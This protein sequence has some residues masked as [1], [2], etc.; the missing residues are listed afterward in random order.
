MYS[1]LLPPTI[2]RR[3]NLRWYDFARRRRQRINIQK[4]SLTERLIDRDRTFDSWS[5][6]PNKSSEIQESGRG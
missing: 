6:P 2:L 4:E 3:E 1:F 5:D